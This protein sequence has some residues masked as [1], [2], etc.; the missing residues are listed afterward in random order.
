MR[1]A[2]LSF[3]ASS[4]VLAMPASATVKPESPPTIDA[5]IG[6]G[7]D[8]STDAIIGT[9]K[10]SSTDAIIG[11]GKTASTNAII[12]TG[13]DSSTDAIIG[14]GKTSSTSA[15]IGTGRTA[16]TNAIIGTGKAA[17]TN[18]IV[19]TGR[20]GDRN[21]ALAGPIEAVDGDKGTFTVLSRTLR[22]SGDKSVLNRLSAEMA[23]GRTPQASVVS[24]LGTRGELD[25]PIVLFVGE[26]YVPGVSE[27][28]V[29]GR[30]TTVDASKGL[31]KIGTS[32]F[33]YTSLLSTDGVD[34][35]VGS[36]VRVRGTQ[37]QSGR[38]ILAVQ[39]VEVSY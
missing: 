6:T 30:V 16:S 21:V 29:T 28:V 2:V 13:K 5:I 20:D 39:V 14:T 36:V 37:P 23:A 9:G 4:L 25:K 7:K 34:L 35:Q 3:V 26:Q 17:S 31:A 10:D 24:E 38:P 32:T 19:G 8:S 27:V 33:D 15:I 12:G 1:T 11:T 22:V 18:A